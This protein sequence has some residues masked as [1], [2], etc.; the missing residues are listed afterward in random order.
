MLLRWLCHHKHFST[1]KTRITHMN[2]AEADSIIR[3]YTRDFN[4]FGCGESEVPRIEIEVGHALPNEFKIYL[5]H[6][7]PR[8]GFGIGSF[9]QG[10]TLYGSTELRLENSKM[11]NYFPEIERNISTPFVIGTD[12]STAIIT[13]LA[14]ESCPVYQVD[15][16]WDWQ[17]RRMTNTLADFLA[18]LFYREYAT[19]KWLEDFELY[20]NAEANR[21]NE[22]LDN[23]VQDLILKLC[24]ESVKLWT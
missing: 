19:D 3:Q 21:L 4:W 9:N 2:F 15:E 6:F 23:E 5:E 20:G 22:K 16:R 13:D 7:V 1:Y 18:I 8:K 14:Q 17:S 12:A 24:P 10:F 11:W